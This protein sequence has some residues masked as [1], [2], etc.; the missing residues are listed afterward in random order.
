MRDFPRSTAATLV[1][2]LSIVL[3]VAG[4]AGCGPKNKGAAPS[5][6]TTS[7]SSTAQFEVGNTLNYGSFG[8]T[9][10]L[11][12]ADGKSLNVG[13]SNNT[14]TVKGTCSSVSIGGADNKITF[15]KVDKQLSVVGLNNTVTY[16]SG[17]PKVENLGSNNTITKG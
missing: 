16:K 17:D 7:G 9:A 6:T 14:L 12:C 1:L 13:G 4:L 2:A 3:A 5:T 15:D 11:D 10:D 8:T